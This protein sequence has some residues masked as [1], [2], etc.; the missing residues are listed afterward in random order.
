MDKL[1]K[2]FATAFFIQTLAFSA[3]AQGE[4]KNAKD[5]AT[6]SSWLTKKFTFNSPDTGFVSLP[7]GNG[8]S[9]NNSGATIKYVILPENYYKVKSQFV[10][11]KATETSLLI[12][13]IQ[14]K[15]SGQEAFSVI[16]EEVSPDQS[17]YENYISTM[18]IAG[19]GNITVCIVGAYPK[20]K[21]KILRKKYIE[22]SLTVKEL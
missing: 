5:S 6:A 8:Y 9:N 4:K 3:V 1:I 17:K 12:D 15:L 20:S 2:V 7:E 18:T 19:I 14:H 21:D 10:E 16:R 22:A 13:T 11:Q